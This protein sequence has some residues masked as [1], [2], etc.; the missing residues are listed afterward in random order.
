MHGSLGTSKRVRF[1]SVALSKRLVAAGANTG[2]VY[3]FRRTD[4]KLVK[5]LSNVGDELSA[6]LKVAICPNEERLALATAQG[7][8]LLVE[9][10]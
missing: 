9:P 7:N 3:V 8:L 6:I 4:L 2:S 10:K 5:L 1:T